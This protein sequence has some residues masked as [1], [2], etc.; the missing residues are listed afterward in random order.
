MPE[1][2]T[3]AIESKAPIRDLLA[4]EPVNK[5]PRLLDEYDGRI[6][7]KLTHAV[8]QRDAQH[9]CATDDP[10]PKNKSQ[11]TLASDAHRGVGLAS[12]PHHR[13]T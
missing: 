6:N 4:Y 11:P 12:D 3:P 7:A 10:L 9:L 8:G 1:H 5:R 13:R 2:V